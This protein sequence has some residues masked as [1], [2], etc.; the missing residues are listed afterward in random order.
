[1]FR[2][3]IAVLLL[4]ALPGAAATA[5]VTKIGEWS[6]ERAPEGC[7]VYSTTD[8]GSVLS[9]SALAGRDSLS[10]LVQNKGWSS[11]E[12]GPRALQVAFDSGRS[13]PVEAVARHDIDSDGPGLLFAVKPASSARGDFVDQFAAASGMR[14]TSNGEQIDSLALSGSQEAL[15]AL[16]QCI[17]DL[18]RSSAAADAGADSDNAQPRAPRWES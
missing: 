13:W 18:W 6:L 1:M 5:Q 15:G 4:A 17:G 3:L 9:V 10:F 2:S 16:A 14:I 8:R 7:M 11:L 12:E